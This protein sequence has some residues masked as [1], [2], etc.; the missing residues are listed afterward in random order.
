MLKATLSVLVM[1]ISY[2]AGAV[3]DLMPK[4]IEV[5]GK[6]LTSVNIINKSD[7]E[8][9]VTVALSRLLNPGV[10]FDQEKLE[11]V[12][13]SRDPQLYAYPFRL[14]L[15]KGQSK[16][17]VLKP[18]T[19]V[20]QEAVYRLYVKPA[21]ALSGTSEGQTTAAGVAVSLS[22][23]ALVRVL[24]DKQIREITTS[25]TAQ[26]VTLTA[27]GTIRYPVKGM[28][29]EGTVL[30]EFNVYPGTPIVI[31]GHDIDIDGKRVCR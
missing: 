2:Q 15:G 11:P 7:H 8:E 27:V 9:F 19:V 4:L 13:M 12:G 6:E 28:K 10:P 5:K 26:G 14:S 21:M 29:V 30:D 17:V 25:C 20:K 31:T 3:I 24:P 23:S 18:L 1:L 22:F 16:T